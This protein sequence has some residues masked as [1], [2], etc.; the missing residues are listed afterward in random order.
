MVEVVDLD[1]LDHSAAKLH[2]QELDV[3]WVSQS[4]LLAGEQ[5]DWEVLGD[6]I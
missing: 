4:V 2:V 3:G 5:R 1:V 6:Q